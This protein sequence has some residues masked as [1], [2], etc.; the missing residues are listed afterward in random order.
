VDH[1]GKRLA[2]L[3]GLHAGLGRGEFIAPHGIAV[4]S[5]GD[6]YVGEVSY[7]AWPLLF[8]ENPRPADLR[9]LQKFQRRVQV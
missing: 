7:T 9:C 2:R 5:R 8:P 3:G 6:V 1:K 4:D